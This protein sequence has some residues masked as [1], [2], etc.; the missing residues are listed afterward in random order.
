[1]ETSVELPQNT[2]QTSL[3]PHQQALAQ[4]T[5]GRNNSAVDRLQ[6]QFEG[7]PIDLHALRSEGNIA[8]GPEAVDRDDLWPVIGAKLD[9]IQF[10]ATENE[11]EKSVPG[12]AV[13]LQNV[14]KKYLLAFNTAYLASWR[15]Q[16]LNVR[17]ADPTRPPQP[18]MD[19]NDLPA[20][21]TASAQNG[22]ILIGIN[23]PHTLNT[24][25]QYTPNI[26]SVVETNRT[27]LQQSLQRQAESRATNNA[28]S[29]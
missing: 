25:M 16:Q 21:S 24:L 11:P 4:M 9:F 1:M 14:Y 22:P 17:H 29:V 26:V 23:D 28:P 7:R 2:P 12:V 18:M 27:L 6:L 5:D 8:G 10:L 3:M 13:H 19:R 15:K 20:P